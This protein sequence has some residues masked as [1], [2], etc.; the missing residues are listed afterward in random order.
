MRYRFVSWGRDASAQDPGWMNDLFFHAAILS[1]RPR[2]LMCDEVRARTNL[3]MQNQN[4]MGFD[5][6]ASWGAACRAPTSNRQDYQQN[7]L[8]RCQG[9]RSSR[10]AGKKNAGWKPARPR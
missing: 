5:V 3:I 9:F 1:R 4:V 10:R 8:P 2:Q 6:W 7:R